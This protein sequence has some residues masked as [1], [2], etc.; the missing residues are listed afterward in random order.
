[1]RKSRRRLTKVSKLHERQFSPQEYLQREGVFQSEQ[2][3]YDEL[4]DSLRA[5]LRKY[6]GSAQLVTMCLHTGY[7]EQEIIAGLQRD[8]GFK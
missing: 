2:S 5:A 4:P 8:A 1:M 7:S 6:G 3:F